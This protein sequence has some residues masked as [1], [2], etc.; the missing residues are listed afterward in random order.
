MDDYLII[1]NPANGGFGSIFRAI[2]EKDITKRIVI[3]KT[4]KKK[5]AKDKT[6]K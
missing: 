2:Q 6:F 1:D 3:M 5:F 4:I